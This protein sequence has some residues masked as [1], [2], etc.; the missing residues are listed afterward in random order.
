MALLLKVDTAAW[1]SRTW[2]ITIR[3]H[4]SVVGSSWQVQETSSFFKRMACQN[5]FLGFS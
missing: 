3:G 2:K 1:N 4:F 5:I